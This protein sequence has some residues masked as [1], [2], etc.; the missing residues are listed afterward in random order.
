MSWMIGIDTGGTFTDVIALD[1]ATGRLRTI[2]TPSMPHDPS[3]AVLNGIAAFLEMEP[4]VESGDIGFLAHGTTV[5]TNAV[6]ERKGVR[7]GLLITKGT[8]AVYVARMSRQPSATDMLNPEFRKPALLIPARQTREI[9]ERLTHDGSVLS[10]LD[11]G[12]VVRAVKELTE[13]HGV[14]SIAVCYLFSFMDPAHERATR[15][16]I[17]KAFPDVRVSLSSDILPIVREYRRLSTTVLD[18]YVGPT[19]DR[20]LRR[21]GDGLTARGVTTPQVFIM[22]S[23]GG[24]MSIDVA[25]ANPVQTLLSGPAA[26]VISGRYLSELLGLPNIVTFDVGGTS[27]DIATIVNGEIT[28]TTEG[29]VAGHDSSVPMNEIGTIGAGGGTIARIG[30]DG[31][32]HVGPDSAGAVPGPV[33]YRRGGEEPTVTDADLVLGFLDPARFLEGRLALD[34]DGATRAIADRLAGPLKLT[35]AEAAFGIVKIVNSNMESE[36]RLNLMARGLNPRDFALVAIGGAG[37]VHASMVAASMGIGTVVV[38]PYPGLGSAMGLLLTDIRHTYL[39]SNPGLLD[40]Y[41][42]DAMNALFDGLEERAR[43]EARREGTDADALAITRILEIRYAGQG[44]ELPVPCGGDRL[45]DADK[46]AIRAAFH[47]LHERTYGHCAQETAV[48]IVNFRVDSL[49]V[50]P[51]LRLPD[52]PPADGGSPDRA[53]ARRRPVCFDGTNKRIDTP[54]YWRPNLRAGDR[55]DGP[56]IVEQADTTTVVIPGQR[57][58]IDRHGNLILTF[59]A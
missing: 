57:A 5:A 11:P 9:G 4:D 51:K 35:V 53:I 45:E 47:R 30:A 3:E 7:T 15:D 16:L 59:A 10:P 34:L 54:V 56:A 58:E 26:G 50:L 27:T 20:Y 49:A 32:L 37:P 42:C 17:R 39:Q 18:A 6:I 36:L 14:T 28:E 29:T 25:S 19:L 2:K 52:C 1:R 8:N 13:A 55:F 23:N 46:P 21:L 38:P 41:D 24:L 43:D 31:R 22:Q 44:Y 48:E 33:C 12:E 40:G